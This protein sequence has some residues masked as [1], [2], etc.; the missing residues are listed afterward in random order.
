MDH[1]PRW[2]DPSQMASVDSVKRRIVASVL[3]LPPVDLPLLESRGLVLAEDVIAEGDVP[4]FRNSAMD[5]YA[6]RSSDIGPSTTLRLAGTIAAGEEISDVL[7]PGTAMR[8]MTGAMVPDGADSVVRFEE[9]SQEAGVVQIRRPIGA[10]ENVRLAGEDVKAGTVVLSR[11]TVLDAP[12]IGILAALNRAS[13][14]VHRRPRIGI[15]STGDEVVD[16]GPKLDPGQI[17]DANAYAM[18]ARVEALGGVAVPLGIARDSAEDIRE[19]IDRAQDCDLILT[20]GGVSVGDFDLV[21]EVLRSEG[22][23]EIMTV[24]M[25]P[26]KPL[27]FGHIGDQPLV[28]LPGNPVA[29]LVSFDQFV[30]P[31]IRK[32]LGHTALEFPVVRARLASSIDNRGRRRHFERGVVSHSEGQWSVQPSEIHGSAMLSSLVAANC[33]I[34]VPEDIDRVGAGS[35]VDVQVLDP[36]ALFR[37]IETGLAP[38]D[39][40]VTQ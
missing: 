12:E 33:Y 9:V 6:V 37:A 8:I 30:H 38:V 25:K 29:A 36:N 17:R 28:G 18:S 5:G 1:T 39:R 16:V 32:M 13:V 4:P 31:A 19:R 22:Q 24:R 7:E 2:D 15:L 21:K 10:G 3:P 34:V 26:G 23:I 11:G 20:S 14:S 40:I 35:I 27:A